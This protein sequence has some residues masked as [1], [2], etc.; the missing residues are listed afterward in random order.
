MRTDSAKTDVRDAILDA[1]DR[2][3][4]FYGYTKTTVDDIA[5][6]AGVGKGTIYLYFKSKE[7][8]AVS[9]VDRVNA[10]LRDQLQRIA[11]SEIA[12]A[13]KFREMLLV[14]ILFRFDTIRNYTRSLDELLAAIRP[15]TLIWRERWQDAEAKIFAQVLTQGEDNGVFHVDDAYQ[16]AR[17]LLMATNSYLPN[18]LSIEQLGE[19]DQIADAVTRMAELLLNG[20]LVR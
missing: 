14:R 20:V 19:R 4:G 13:D 9:W 12:P 17:L 11:D 5:H 3:I 15:I 18:N 10:R 16:T 6:E 2:L 7:E 1:A 8:V